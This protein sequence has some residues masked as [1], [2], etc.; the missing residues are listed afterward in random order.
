MREVQH[1]VNAT[2][3]IGAVVQG[4]EVACAQLGDTIVASVV[5]AV[6]VGQIGSLRDGSRVEVTPVAR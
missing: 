4:P 2:G 5:T 1:L 3:T 6:V